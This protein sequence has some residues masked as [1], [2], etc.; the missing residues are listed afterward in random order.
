MPIY[1]Y[2]C[3]DCGNIVE[4]LIRTSDSS[5]PACPSCR[6]EH[7]VKQ[8]SAGYVARFRVAPHRTSCCGR[9]EGCEG[10]GSGCSEPGNCCCG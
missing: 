9:E 6:G 5:P 1:D 3:P 7:L 8:P 4:V 10:A 2:K